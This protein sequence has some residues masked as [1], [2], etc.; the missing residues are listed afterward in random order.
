[1]PVIVPTRLFVSSLVTLMLTSMRST[2]VSP[3]SAVPRNVRPLLESVFACDVA[4]RERFA[5]SVTFTE[6]SFP[7]PV[8]RKPKRESWLNSRPS[9]SAPVATMR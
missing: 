7:V 2:S 5:G 9:R 6:G 4:L 1:M 8:P 3:F